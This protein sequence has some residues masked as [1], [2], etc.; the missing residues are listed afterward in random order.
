M[1]YSWQIMNAVLSV[2]S[3]KW[4]HGIGLLIKLANDINSHTQNDI[5]SMKRYNDLWEHE[6]QSVFWLNETY[7]RD[8]VE[9]SIWDRTVSHVPRHRH[10][11]PWSPQLH[12]PLTISH[13]D[14]VSSCWYQ[15]S[16]APQLPGNNKVAQ[17][18]IKG[19]AWPLL[20]S[21]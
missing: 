18:T 4:N 21:L 7:S 9:I 17:P 3:K 15:V 19:V 8:P 13:I 12:N 11:T 16:S 20:L 6:R 2:P 1:L 14:N 5:F 10:L